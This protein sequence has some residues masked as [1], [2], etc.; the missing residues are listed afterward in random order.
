MIQSSDLSTGCRRVIGCFNIIFYFPQKSPILNGSFAERDLQFQAS[1]ASLPPCILSYDPTIPSK[2]HPIFHRE[3]CNVYPLCC[4]VLQCVAVCCSVLRCVVVCCIVLQYVAVCGSVLQ[5]A[6]VFCSVMQSLPV[7]YSVLQCV[8]MCCIVIFHFIAVCCSCNADPTRFKFNQ[9]KS[10]STN[11]TVYS[12][13]SA[14]F[15]IKHT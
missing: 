1:N 13:K 9:N 6:A 15:S 4:S 11:R 14:V 3:H 7:C 12:I 8:A 5:C 2:L 10:Y